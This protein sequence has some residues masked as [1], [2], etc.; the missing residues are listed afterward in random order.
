MLR[1]PK[2][3]LE[4]AWQGK[5]LVDVL[6]VKFL[7]EKKILCRNAKKEN[8]NKSL[9]KKIPLAS[10]QIHMTSSSCGVWSWYKHQTSAKGLGRDQAAELGLPSGSEAPETGKNTRSEEALLRPAP[11][12]TPLNAE[13]KP[14][15]TCLPHRRQQKYVL[16]RF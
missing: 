8:K 3:Q 14:V 4:M 2:K 5:E 13:K 15:L 16:R 6:L 9:K 11:M 1:I 12:T 7:I 10:T